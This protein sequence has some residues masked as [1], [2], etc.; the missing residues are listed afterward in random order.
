[1]VLGYSAERGS[2][3]NR[4]QMETLRLRCVQVDSG[5]LAGRTRSTSR[6][7][8]ETEKPTRVG[9]GFVLQVS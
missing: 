4:F 6:E 3:P 2:I 8:L 5:S 1:M 9:V 7:D